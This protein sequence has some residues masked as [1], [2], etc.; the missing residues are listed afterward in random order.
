MDLGFGKLKG[1]LPSVALLFVRGGLLFYC[2]VL[3]N[4]GFVVVYWPIRLS[5]GIALKDSLCV[6]VKLDS[7]LLIGCAFNVHVHESI[8][9]V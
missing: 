3:G 7:L 5:C 9:Q 1:C 8:L 2:R 4:L 6:R